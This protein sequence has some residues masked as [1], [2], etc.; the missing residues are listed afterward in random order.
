[1]DLLDVELATCFAAGEMIKVQPESM[2]N[3]LIAVPFDLFF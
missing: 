2:A 1:M 3:G